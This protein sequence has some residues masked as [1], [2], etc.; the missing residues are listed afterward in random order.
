VFSGTARFHAELTDGSGLTYDVLVDNPTEHPIVRVITLN[1]GAAVASNLNIEYTLDADL[2]NPSNITLQ[3]ATLAPATVV[4][5][6]ISPEQGVFADSVDVTIASATPNATIR[7]TTDGSAPISTSTAYTG[8]FTLT[9]DATVRA[10]GF[11]AGYNDSAEATADFTNN[12]SSG[13]SKLSTLVETRS[14]NVDLTAEGTTDWSHWGLNAPPNDLDQRDD[15]GPVN[16][17]GDYT[18]LPGTPAAVR[19]SDVPT[20]FSW[21]ADGTPTASASDST[22]GIFFDLDVGE[23]YSLSVPAD[24]TEKT[25]KVYLGVFSG[26]ARFHAE[27][28]DGSGLSADVFVDNPTEHPIVRVITLNFGADSASNLDIEYTLE[29]DSG[30]PDA[31]IT[32]QAATLAQ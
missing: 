29:T 27:L 9:G 18:P 13:S 4:K 23:G 11:L 22:T 6:T 2:G 3:A 15:G 8:P 19:Y 30:D 12:P 21:T 28:T 17:I 14:E 10:K 5:A 24:A 32:L 26:T 1:F 31:N 25:L 16:I 20:G 7:Y